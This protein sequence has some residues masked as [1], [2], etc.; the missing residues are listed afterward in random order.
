M[1]CCRCVRPHR[2]E[3]QSR[4]SVARFLV[5][6]LVTIR[7]GNDLRTLLRLMSMSVQ[8]LRE[9]ST[10]DAATQR[11]LVELDGAIESAFQIARELIAMGEP[12]QLRQLE[13]MA[14]PKS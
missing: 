8:S 12:A 5:S 4:S 3:A 2:A 11:D 1:G 10:T 9:R 14:S 6:T 7:L 13:Q